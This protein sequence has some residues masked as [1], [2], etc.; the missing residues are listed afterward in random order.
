[1][2]VKRGG[3]KKCMLYT[4]IGC[5]RLHV[6]GIRTEA[7]CKNFYINKWGGATD[8]WHVLHFTFTY[9]FFLQKNV[10]SKVIM[11]VKCNEG[12]S[13]YTFFFVKKM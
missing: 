13:S 5:T 9:T 3:Y 2:D 12:Y 4:Q 8:R 1:M 7:K 11:C 10:S 6:S